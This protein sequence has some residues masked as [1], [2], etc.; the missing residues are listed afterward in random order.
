[1]AG[2]QSSPVP[3]DVDR[4]ARINDMESK[5]A[6]AGD[7]G[8]KDWQVWL[9]TPEEVEFWQGAKD[10]NHDRLKYKRTEGG[11]ERTTLWP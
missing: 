4:A 7:V 10:R 8:F 5:L 1:M 9:I 6:E 2:A 11:W 3:P